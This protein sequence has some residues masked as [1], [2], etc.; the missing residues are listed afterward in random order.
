MSPIVPK[1]FG[2]PVAYYL[3]RATLRLCTMR[4]FLLIPL[5]FLGCAKSTT[6][7][8]DVANKLQD[9]SWRIVSSHGADS[10]RNFT[11]YHFVS[12]TAGTYRQV[13]DLTYEK[14]V[15]YPFTYKLE[16]SASGDCMITLTYGKG[17]EEH[18]LFCEI[19]ESRLIL[20]DSKSGERSTF[21]P[22]L[23]EESLQEV[24]P[25]KSSTYPPARK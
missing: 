14:G 2:I 4:A 1:S 12:D 20:T 6:R 22:F 5:L 23:N 25:R 8:A 3:R 13:V 18:E 11:E 7:V 16:E 10:S 21:E 24:E 15:S 9:G 19:E 17:S